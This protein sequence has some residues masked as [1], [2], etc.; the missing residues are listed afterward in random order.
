MWKKTGSPKKYY[1]QAKNTKQ[2]WEKKGKKAKIE[3]T[4][5]GKYQ[6]YIRE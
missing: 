6:V 1:L 2:S 3:E 4:K 5:T